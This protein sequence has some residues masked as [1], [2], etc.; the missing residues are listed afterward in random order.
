MSEIVEPDDVPQ[1]MHPTF[2]AA[3]GEFSNSGN[4]IDPYFPF[5]R[6]SFFSLATE[7]DNVQFHEIQI[8]ER[9]FGSGRAKLIKSRVNSLQVCLE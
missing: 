4:V 3:V 8:F 2:Q 1:R 9:L 5:G 6:V 7:E